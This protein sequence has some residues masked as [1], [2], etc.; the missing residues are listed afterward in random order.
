MK[1]PNPAPR[2]HRP[3]LEDRRILGVP[4]EFVNER[5]RD[6]FRSD[7]WAVADIMNGGWSDDGFDYFLG[8][9]VLRGKQA[10]E[11]A[12]ANPEDVAKGVSPDG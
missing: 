2:P 12:L 11:A 7:L 4:I 5:I 10:Y 1:K 9:L 6:A 8:W 3:A